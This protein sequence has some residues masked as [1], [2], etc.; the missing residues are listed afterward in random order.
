MQDMKVNMEYSQN[1][2]TSS[3]DINTVRAEREREG[4]DYLIQYI[5]TYYVK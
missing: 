3:S 4:L 2:N 5:Y 1:S